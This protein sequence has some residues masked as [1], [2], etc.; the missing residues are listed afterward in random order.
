[1][2]TTQ[3]TINR[4]MHKHTGYSDNENYSKQRQSR[5]ELLIITNVENTYIHTHHTYT[6]TQL[7]MAALLQ[8]PKIGNQKVYQNVY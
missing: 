4:K 3:V 1:M 8:E 2:E 7:F 5:P 6:H